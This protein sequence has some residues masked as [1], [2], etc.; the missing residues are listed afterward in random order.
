MELSVNDV[1]KGADLAILMMDDGRATKGGVAFIH[2]FDLKRAMG[3]VSW[4]SAFSLRTLVHEIG[5]IF[6]AEHDRKNA[7]PANMTKYGYEYGWHLDYPKES[8]LYSIMA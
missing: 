6:G 1:Y 2:G 5:H 7:Q 4:K 8:G 3:V